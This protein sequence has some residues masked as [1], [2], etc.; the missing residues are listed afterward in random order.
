MNKDC[1]WYADSLTGM[2]LGFDER[3][4]LPKF[5][6]KWVGPFSSLTEAQASALGVFSHPST[7]E[8]IGQCAQRILIAKRLKA[9][10]EDAA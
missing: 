6:V 3:E 2:F 8:W 4:D 10:R 9:K 5:Q 7:R 1:Y